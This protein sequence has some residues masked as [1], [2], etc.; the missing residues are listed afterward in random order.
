M[1]RVPSSQTQLMITHCPLVAETPPYR[2][3]DEDE[4]FTEA[5]EKRFVGL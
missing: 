2:E 5:V 1:S 3:T 4:T